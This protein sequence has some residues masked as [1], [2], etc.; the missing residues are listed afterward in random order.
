MWLQGV[1]LKVR[2]FVKIFGDRE[3]FVVADNHGVE[4]W[5]FNPK[6]TPN[7]QNWIQR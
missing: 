6:Y 1:P 7:P 2:T 5:I 4:L 3:A